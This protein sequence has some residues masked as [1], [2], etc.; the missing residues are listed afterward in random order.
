VNRGG[1]NISV[2]GEAEIAKA[3]RVARLFGLAALQST[4]EGSAQVDLQI[5]GTWAG[6]SN[7]T[8]SGF[9]G[10][11]VTGM[12]KLR[13]VRIAIRGAAEPV[14]IAAADMQLLP[15]EVRVAKLN[16]KAADT[17]WTG[18]LT[19]P[20]GC[21][22]PGACQ[23]HFVLN[24]NQI[25]LGGLSEWVR[26]SP[27][28]RPWYRVLE[29]SPQAG[30]SFLASVRAS[31]QVT[32][33]RLQVQGLAAT[34]VSAKVN[35]DSGKLEI[36]D[37]NAD[38]LGGKHRGQW[39]ADFSVKPTICSGSGSLT[40]VSLARLADAMKSGGIAGI[41]NTSYDAKGPCTAGFWT[42]AEGALQFEIRDGSLPHVALGEDAEGLRVARFAGEARL[43]AGKIEL[44]DAHLNSPEGKFLVGG[45]ASLKG[46]LDLRMAKIPSGAAAVG[47]TISGTL[48][49]P[50]VIRSSS[51]ETQA[52]LKP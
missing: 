3:L 52:R 50:R 14:E 39:Q 42:L 17:L 1:Y 6:R 27:K 23:V 7:G 10:P 26:P 19:M 18:S 2:A 30:P 5:A 29:S 45:T 43:Q 15:D 4:T 44:K 36:S 33:D 49:E 25:A 46:E 38:F 20:R 12:A 41:A 32:A 22:T 31:G 51:P 35:L 16:A 11:Q 13:N 9:T 34:R 24:A 37:L 47:Y 48:A 8:T 21:G 40:G 28:E